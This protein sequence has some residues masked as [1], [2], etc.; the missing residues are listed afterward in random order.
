[1]PQASYCDERP[2]VVGMRVRAMTRIVEDDLPPADGVA[3]GEPGW[4]HCEAGDAGTVEAV[5]DGDPTVRFD[6]SGTATMCAPWEV[7]VAPWA[8]ITPVA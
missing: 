5:D 6:V 8:L 2:F 7:E 1:M 3:P 4:L